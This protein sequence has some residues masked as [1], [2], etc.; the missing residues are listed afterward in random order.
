MQLALLAGIIAISA[1]MAGKKPPS[2]ALESLRSAPEATSIRGFDFYVLALSWSPSYCE[3]KGA[4]ADREQCGSGKALGFTVHGLWPQYERGFPTDCAV[5]DAGGVD[6]DTLREIDPILPSDGL[7]RHE[8]RK[9]G[10]CSG[11]TQKAYFGALQRAFKQVRIPDAYRRVEARRSVAP[12]RVEADFVTAN[13][14]MQ[15]GGIAAICDEGNLSEVRICMAKDLS[16]RPCAQVDKSACRA[17]NVDL[18]PMK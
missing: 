4:G 5:G 2:P 13:S 6:R 8:W 3:S 1:F 12:R 9:H 18:P 10:T 16:F 17:A 14:G 11:L 15:A 7:A